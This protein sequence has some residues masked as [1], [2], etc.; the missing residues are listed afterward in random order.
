MITT[1]QR[2]DAVAVDGRGEVCGQLTL[3]FREAHPTQRDVAALEQ[4]GW[5]V[6]VY[7]VEVE[8][9]DPEIVK[10]TYYA[11]PLIDLESIRQLLHDAKLATRAQLHRIL[12]ATGKAPAHCD[13]PA[14][15]LDEQW[16]LT[17][18]AC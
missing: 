8:F 16:D 6:D 3:F 17:E 4:H 7:P 18:E 10:L 11:W 15:L 1:L 9:T 14:E 5:L 12:A 2:I 13:L